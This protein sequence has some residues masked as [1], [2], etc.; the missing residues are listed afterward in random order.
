MGQKV[1]PYLPS[2]KWAAGTE[3]YVPACHSISHN[4][5]QAGVRTPVRTPYL[6]SVEDILHGQ[7]GHNS[8]HLFATAQ[9]HRHD[10]HFAEHWLQRKLRHLQE[11]EETTTASL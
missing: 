6:G 4:T 3:T 8:Q 9:M 11:E 10:E 2:T 5:A 7:H 1:I